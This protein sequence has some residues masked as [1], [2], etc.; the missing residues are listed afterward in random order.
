MARAVPNL[1]A[2]LYL[3]LSLGRCRGRSSRERPAR[4][5]SCRSGRPTS[6]GPRVAQPLLRALPACQGRRRRGKRAPQSRALRPHHVWHQATVCILHLSAL[7]MQVMRVHGYGCHVPRM[8]T[9]Q[10]CAHTA[11][12]GVSPSPGVLPSF[13]GWHYR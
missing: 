8:C 4:A 7:T 13:C 6:V 12:D 10:G 11:L 2:P 5:A 1:P 9:N 3:L